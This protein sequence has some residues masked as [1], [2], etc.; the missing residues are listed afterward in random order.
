MK[1]IL[2]LLLFLFSI[3][4]FAH[5][6]PNTVIALD[7][8]SKKINC[9]LKL[10]LKELQ[11]VVPFDVT[12]NTQKLIEN[13]G[14]YLSKYILSHFTILGSNGKKWNIETNGMTV[15][16]SQQQDTGK[17][18]EL[19]VSLSIFPKE[20][21]NIRNFTIIYDAIMHQVVTHRALITVRQD[22][23]NGN[24]GESNT[25]IGT[26]NINID[27]NMPQPFKVNLKEGSNWKGFESMVALGMKHIYE[28]IDHLL[29]L[30][31][32]LLS[33]PLISNGKKWIGFGGNRYSLI[34]ILKIVTAFTIGHSITLI[35]GSFGL[36]N[37]NAKWVEIIIAFSILITAIHAIRPLFPNKEVYVAA[38]FGLIHGLAFATILS[39]LNLE[40][41][42]LALSLLGFNIG[43]E[44]M[45]LFVIVLVIPWFLLLAP[46]KIYKRIQIIGA[47]IGGIAAMAW[48]VERITE[49]PNFISVHLQNG[50]KFSVWVVFLLACFTVFYTALNKSKK[51][52]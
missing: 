32:L 19:I 17:Y 11:L 34:R 4:V 5:P 25:E 41:N 37:S 26:I 13:H 47:I 7:V 44:L 21:D 30:L 38:G 40:T 24:L 46:H 22:W 16:E 35:I 2:F 45:Q 52:S 48:L 29:F 18:K 14:K 1:K 33:A 36:I 42:K 50:H 20:T 3:T 51:Q 12:K 9:E 28:G 43:I 8:H 27:T 31:V 10:P 49:K 23:E 39:D 15:L 6:M